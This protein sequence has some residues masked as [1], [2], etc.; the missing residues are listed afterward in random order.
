MAPNLIS[1]VSI[2]VDEA[3]QFLLVRQIAVGIVRLVAVAA[4]MLR[5][6]REP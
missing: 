1:K 4:R 2:V 6:L 5:L 3:E